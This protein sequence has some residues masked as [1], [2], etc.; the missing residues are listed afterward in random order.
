VSYARVAD[1]VSP[2]EYVRGV[3]EGRLFD[4]NLTKQLRKGFTVGTLIPNY[5][6]DAGAHGWGA[7]ILWENADYDPTLKTP[8]RPVSVRGYRM[9]L[10]QPDRTIGNSTA[11]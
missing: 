6:L 7:V 4:N 9:A 5:V 1:Q 11:L 8:R 3:V 10:R 2:E